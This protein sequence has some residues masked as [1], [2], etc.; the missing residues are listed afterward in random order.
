MRWQRLFDDLEAQLAAEDARDLVAEVADRTRRERAL[1][2]LH[3]RLLSMQGGPP[4]VFRV[5]GVGT[6]AGLVVGVGPDWV[7]LAEG[8]GT[9]AGSDG[10]HD[11]S[12]LVCYPA[13][14]AVSGLVGRMPEKPPGAVAKGFALGAALRAISRDRAVVEVH[15]VDGHVVIGT[16]DAIGQDLAE[17][18]EHPADLPRRPEHVTGI[19]AV[20]FWSIALV[21]RR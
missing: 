4:V 15:D 20:P 7:L 12:V 16:L 11:R 8:A 9:S 18:A 2:G 1:L 17:V 13:V 5:G 19:R 10:G 3:E 21:R 14:R 6:V